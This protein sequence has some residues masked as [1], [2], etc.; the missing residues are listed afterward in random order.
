MR[1]RA[2]VIAAVALVVT[3]VAYTVGFVW[4]AEVPDQPRVS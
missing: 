3:A 2:D 1:R 4:R